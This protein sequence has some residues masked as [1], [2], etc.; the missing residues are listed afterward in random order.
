MANKNKTSWSVSCTPKILIDNTDTH[1][2]MLN[3]TEV[4]HEDVRK[5]LGGSGE[6][7]GNDV[8]VAGFANGTAATVSSNG[9]TVP[10]H[11][12]QTDLIYIK[13]LGTLVADGSA[14]VAAD[15]VLVK[16]D[17]DTIATLPPGGAL[18]LP[19]PAA[20]VLTLASGSAHVD[21][22]VLVV[23]T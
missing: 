18:V 2:N 1:V 22:E 7:T 20:A 17:S 8:T 19:Q 4:I 3:N 23:G 13:N 15:T 5:S 11:D 12:A 21:T 9:G 10:T 16:H 6:I 14:A